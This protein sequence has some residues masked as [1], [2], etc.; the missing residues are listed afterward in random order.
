[1]ALRAAERPLHAECPKSECQKL[2][3][4]RYPACMDGTEPLRTAAIWNSW[5]WRG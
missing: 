2:K 3:M 1:M 4:V 5:Y